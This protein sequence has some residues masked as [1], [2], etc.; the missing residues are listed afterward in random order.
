MAAVLVGAGHRG[1]I[2]ASYAE[3]HPDEMKIVGVADKI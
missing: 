3:H 1:L 2:Y